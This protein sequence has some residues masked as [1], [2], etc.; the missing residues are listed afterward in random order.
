MT[1][2][3]QKELYDAAQ[4]WAKENGY[5]IIITHSTNNDTQKR[6]TYQCDRSGNYYKKKKHW[7]IIIKEPHHNH[8]PSED[9]SAHAIHRRLNE[10]QKAL[11]N[12]L[13]HA[14][15]RPLQ[16]K[17][18]LMQET[19]TPCSST[20]NTIYNHRNQMRIDHLQGRSP[21]EALVFEIR[22]LDFYHL[23]GEDEGKMKSLF[24]A[25]PNSLTLAKQFP[26]TFLLDC[27]YKTNKYKMP[28]LHIVGMNSCNRSFSVAFCFL[29]AKKAEDYIWA[30][31]QFSIV[32]DGQAPLVLATDKEQALINAIEQVF[33]DTCHLLCSW[34]IYKNVK[35]QCHKNFK[36]EEEWDLFAKCW[37]QLVASQTETDYHQNF[38]E[39]SKKWDPLTAD[40][41]IPNWMPIKE[42]FVAYLID[43]HPHF[44][45]TITS[46]VEGLHAYIKRF[47]NSPTSSFSAVVKHIHRAISVQLHKC[48][49]KASQDSYKQLVGLPPSIKNLN[50][51]ITHFALHSFHIA[52]Q[53]IT[54]SA[55]EGTTFRAED[56]HKQWHVRSNLNG[57]CSLASLPISDDRAPPTRELNEQF[58]LDDLF[59]KFQ[60]FQPGEQS[61]YISQIHKLFEGK[62][63][64][65]AMKE[66]KVEGIRGRPNGASGK[67][68]IST[69]S[70]KRDPSAHEYQEEKK[71]RGRPKKEGTAE[72]KVPKKRGR[73]RKIPV[74]EEEEEEEFE[75]SNEDS[76][77]GEL[78]EDLLDAQDFG[79]L[80]TR[81]GRNSKR[82][83]F[84]EDSKD[85]DDDN[86]KDNNDVSNQDGNNTSD[87]DNNE[88]GD[89]DNNEIS[90]KY[91][92][93]IGDRPALWNYSLG[94]R[95]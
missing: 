12:Q 81:S 64:L 37:H 11:V 20:L 28:V 54:N 60:A 26:T 52:K 77:D 58:F 80:R 74:E 68:H 73:P 94:N 22:N 45:N 31:E 6:F 93:R 35:L 9:S 46:R 67:K 53:S 84:E 34:H 16:I 69:T 2:Q 78:P 88:I 47:I 89:K 92:I 30:L 10:D 8:P 66:P 33:P 57:I 23:I 7:K 61:F 91:N 55:L 17:S 21:I 75:S 29:S 71:K 42:K 48:L 95:A 63:A 44:G 40:Y 82:V 51:T 5:A 41:L 50:G 65:V 4:S 36:S 49:V 39:I 59:L 18:A 56:F 83:K 3:S 32:L 87:K 1:Y 15:V 86:N 62:Y 25:Y 14:G 72:P 70:T 24:F 13:T 43:K 19:E 27:T 90:D 38:A 76:L 85:D 79:P